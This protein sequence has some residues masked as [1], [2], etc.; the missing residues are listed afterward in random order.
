MSNSITRAIKA[1]RDDVHF[2]LGAAAVTIGVIIGA[3]VV[4]IKPNTTNK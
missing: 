2:I 1:R 4:G 3:S